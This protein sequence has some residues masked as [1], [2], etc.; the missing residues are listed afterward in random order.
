MISFEKKKFKTFIVKS[1]EYNIDPTFIS[2]L[3]LIIIV[4]FTI[5]YLGCFL[6]A[7]SRMHSNTSWIDNYC[8]YR[9]DLDED[10]CVRDMNLGLKYSSSVY[11][12]LAM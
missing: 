8:L 4:I 2:L 5:H 3:N 6:F 11:W 10:I 7:I 12:S 9:T 1:D